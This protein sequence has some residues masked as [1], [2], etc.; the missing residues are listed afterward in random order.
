M[1]TNRDLKACKEQLFSYSA[2]YQV[3]FYGREK[4]IE[5]MQG[6]TDGLKPRQV[7][8]ISQP[9]GTGKTFLVNYMINNQRIPVPAGSTFLT[10]KGIAEDPEIMEDFP[11][12]TLVV[13]EADI[14]TPVKKLRKG[15]KLLAEYLDENECKAILL[16]DYS[17]RN[18]AISGCLKY[19]VPLL[20]FEDIDQ[21][22]LR[23]VLEQRFK[24]FLD[25]EDFQIDQVMEPELI[26]YLAPEWMK[27][28]NSFRGIFSLFQKIVADD[29]YVRYNGEAAYLTIETFRDFLCQDQTLQLD[30]N[31]KKFWDMLCEYLR[32][33]YPKGNGI[34]T[35]FTDT[36]L[37]EL[38]KNS[39]ISMSEQTF[40]EEILYPFAAV[41]LL[42]STGIPEYIIESKEFVRRPAP[43]VPSLRLLLSVL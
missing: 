29:R 38:A 14:K 3:P 4:T 20:H 28:V 13:D 19:T 26:D 34:A 16:G 5:E 24:H 8:T 39:G 35:G 11:G 31:Q 32:E 41:D 42:A 7:L 15:L 36:E 12:D 18:P 9:L 25:L 27:S 37:Y 1:I 43:Y 17:L 23:G 33:M 6:L 2:A 10:V 30:Q 22:F 21:A 40:K